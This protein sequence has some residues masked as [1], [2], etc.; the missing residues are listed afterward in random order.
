MRKIDLSSLETFRAVVREGGVVRAASKLHRVQSNVTTRIKQLEQRLGVALFHRQGRSLALTPAGER[1]L[2]Y[3]E[4]LLRLADA[5]EEAVRG[6]P[7]GRP[8][9]VGA[10][11][12]TA[13]SR[14][15]DVLSRL[16]QSLPDI[17]IALQTGPTAML[18]QQVREYRLDA[19]FVGDPFTRDD[20]N[21]RLVFEEELVLVTSLQRDGIGSAADLAADTILAFARGCSYRRVLEDWIAGAGVKPARIAELGSYHAIIACAAAGGGCGIVPVSVLDTLS[22]GC[23]VRRHALPKSIAAV[24][25]LERRGDAGNPGA[26]GSSA[27][28]LSRLPVRCASNTP[29]PSSDRSGRPATPT[30]PLLAQPPGVRSS[31]RFSAAGCISM[32]VSPATSRVTKSAVMRTREMFFCSSWTMIHHERTR[33]TASGSTSFRSGHPAARK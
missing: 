4:R 33:R 27:R 28:V 31:H 10:M 29:N 9:R 7:G 22:A 17:Q 24:P 18:I 11:E 12:S 14:L 32:A 21:A 3:S 13:A 16:H 26:P 2:V 1:L 19:A 5:A 15:P 20:L 23:R 6:V 30:R 25:D 8:F